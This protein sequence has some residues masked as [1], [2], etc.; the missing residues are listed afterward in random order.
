MTTWAV[1]PVKRFAGAKCRLADMLAPEQRRQ[2]SSAM[3]RDLLAAL[4]ATPGLDRIVLA[5]SEPSAAAFGCPVIGDGGGDLNAAIARAAVALEAAG[6]ARMLV[7]AADI[8]LAAPV[9][10]ARVLAAGQAAPVVIV[11]D[12][13]GLGTNALLL[14]P[15]SAIAPRFGA[16]SCA[17]HAA[18][19]R[20]LGLASRELHLPS[21]GFDVDEPEDLARLVQSTVDRA[22]YGF[23]ASTF[24]AAE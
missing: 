9:E 3:L 20:D 14:A 15:P 13:R 24:E 4:T 19:A 21:L 2:L 8:P 10:I 12:A 7:I 1:V 6:V 23:L 18:A 22:A 16:D 11:P 5:T 17:R